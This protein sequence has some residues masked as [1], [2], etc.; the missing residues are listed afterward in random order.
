M[1]KWQAGQP[2][3]IRARICDFGVIPGRATRLRSLRERR[4]Y[5]FRR[6]AERVGGSASPES[7][8]TDVENGLRNFSEKF[9]AMDSGL[10]AEPVIGPATLG[11]TRW[12]GPGMTTTRLPA[13]CGGRSGRRRLARSRAACRAPPAL[14]ARRRG[15]RRPSNRPRFAVRWCT[16]RRV[17]I[18]GAP[19]REREALARG[20]FIHEERGRSG[21]P[22]NSRP[23]TS[24]NPMSSC[25]GAAQRRAD[26]LR[27]PLHQMR[28]LVARHLDR[29]ADLDHVEPVGIERVG[30][31]A[32]YIGRARRSTPRALQPASPPA[33]K[34]ATIAA[35]AAAIA[36]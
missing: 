31:K 26:P 1:K 18:A 33:R 28:P 4:W 13:G 27:Q 5:E 8:I 6:S 19:A 24:F 14:T 34:A 3:T 7:I 20:V 30:G 9:V 32:R 16:Q 35:A 12:L 23:P 15:R 25:M 21:R 11:R 17:A 10:L 29:V 22:G 2:A 36:P